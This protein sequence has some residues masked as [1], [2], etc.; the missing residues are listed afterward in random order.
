[1]KSSCSI[2]KVHINGMFRLFRDGGGDGVGRGGVGRG[3][4][5]VT[6][7]YRFL[8][9]ISIIYIYKISINT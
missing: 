4:R 6:K 2:H 3:V 5:T 9:T 8:K 1:M 7:C